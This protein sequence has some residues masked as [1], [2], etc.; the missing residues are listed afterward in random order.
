[1]PNQ[2]LRPECTFFVTMIGTLAPPVNACSAVSDDFPGKKDLE[3]AHSHSRIAVNSS[4]RARTQQTNPTIK[5]FRASPGEA[6]M[7]IL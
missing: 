6:R 5:S 1:M 3:L 7:L 4:D 2:K